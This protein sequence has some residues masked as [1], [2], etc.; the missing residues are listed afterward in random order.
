[1]TARSAAVLGESDGYVFADINGLRCTI[2]GT[3]ETAFITS[4]VMRQGK[5]R[6]DSPNQRGERRNP[7]LCTGHLRRQQVMR[8]CGCLYF[9]EQVI[10]RLS[11]YVGRILCA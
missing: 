6:G 2:P 4:G 5:F 1:M 3:L 7:F 11:S 8:E 9:A 10:Y